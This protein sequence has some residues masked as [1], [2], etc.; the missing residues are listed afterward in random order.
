MA[1]TQ[2][3]EQIFAEALELRSLSER[4][5]FLERACAGDTQLRRD[6]ETLLHAHEEAGDFLSDA[7]PE[8]RAEENQKTIHVRATLPANH[9]D[10]PPS[11]SGFRIERKLGSGGIGVV[12]EAWDEKLQRKVALKTLHAVSN[13]E[14]R[15]RVLDEARKTAALHDPAIVTVHAVLDEHEPPAI[16]MELVEGFPIDQYAASLTYEQKARVLQEIARALAAAHHRGIIHRD[17]KPANVLLT[18]AM[19]PVVLDFGLAISFEEADGTSSRFEGTP[20]Y[21]SPEQ[22]SGKRVS[23][24]SDIFSFGS[25]MFKVLTGTT[26]FPGDN[27]SEVLT[28][29]RA[30]KPPFLR[31]VAVGVP[32]DLQAICLACLAANPDERPTAE[33]VALDLGR[34]LANEPVRLRPALYGDILRRRISEYSNDL[35]NWE[36]QG[37]ISSDERDRLQVV[38]RRILADEDHWLIDARRLTLAQTVLYTSTWLVVVAAGLIV[39]LVREDLPPVARWLLPLFGTAMLIAVGLLAEYRKEAL[40]SAAFLAGAVLSLVPTT[41]AILAE[42]HWWATPVENVQQLFA[43]PFTNQQVLVACLTGFVFSIFALARLRMTG[44]AWTSCV[45]GALS[46]V[47]FLLQLNWLDRKPEIQMLWLLPLTSCS[48]VALA[49]ENKGRVRWALPFHLV[50]LLVLIGALDVMASSG[51]TLAMLGLDQKFSPFLNLDR[52]KYLSFASNGL[53]F[54]ALMLLTENSRSLDLRRG[55]RLLEVVAIVH[56]LGGLYGNAQQQRAD[57]KVLVDVSLYV[58]AVLLF[59]VLGPWR[60]RWRMLVGALSGVALGSYLLIDLNLVPRKPFV[61][62]LGAIGLLT[63]LS[64]YTYLLVVPRLRDAQRHAAKSANTIRH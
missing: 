21:T 42:F 52:Q 2:S 60:S 32:A 1:D 22:A 31:D 56:L 16:V 62:C 58:S 29:I 44:F 41:F 30:A 39:W 37:M 50:A 17:L 49:F 9:F 13:A 34:F 28:A 51:P 20:L 18:P 61:L 19:K 7:V 53:L 33:E 25:L 4:Q 45:I 43:P 8:P 24:A 11:I 40:A 57:P 48:F 35:L 15:R 64:A 3:T 47:S 6:V 54:L 12:Y 36:H 63:A 38:H 55:S 46:Y 27:L 14:T 26:P 59:L 10:H 23:A 5:R